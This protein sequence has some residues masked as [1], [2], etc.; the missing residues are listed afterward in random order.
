MILYVDSLQSPSVD[1]NISLQ[2]PSV[3]NNISSATSSIDSTQLVISTN[4][5]SMMD[6]LGTYVKALEHENSNL[7]QIISECLH[8]FSSCRREFLE[9]SLS[10]LGL[11]KLSI[12]DVHKMQWHDIEDEIERWIKGFNVA[13]KILFPS[14]RR[15]CDRV[16][17]GFSS[18]ADFSFMEVCRGS[19]V[20]L[21]NF[22][23]AVAIGSRS[24]ER[25]FKILDVFETLRDLISEFEL[26]FCDHYSV[27]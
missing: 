14:E 15:L 17:F 9:Q 6:Q 10:R 26:L 22:A 1:N 18:A 19:T 27:S 20:Q 25:L 2:T 3:N 5:G 21:L 4:I 16:F 24:P 13:L 8:V 23:D 12:E 11:Q 7:I